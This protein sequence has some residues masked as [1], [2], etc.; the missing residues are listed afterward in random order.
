MEG[1]LRLRGNIEL[2]LVGCECFQECHHPNLARS[3]AKRDKKQG[4]ARGR[5]TVSAF[6]D[7]MILVGYSLTGGACGLEQA[8]PHPRAVA[9]LFLA[10]HVPPVHVPDGLPAFSDSNLRLSNLLAC[11][12]RRRA[13]VGLGFGVHRHRGQIEDRQRRR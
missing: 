10:G 6:S 13:V 3:A 8:A 5:R 1:L 7:F 11:R 2:G 4:D 9:L 12:G